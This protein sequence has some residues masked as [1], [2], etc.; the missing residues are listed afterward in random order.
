MPISDKY[1][2]PVHAMQWTGYNNASHVLFDAS[3]GITPSKTPCDKIDSEQPWSQTHISL[4][5][6]NG[7]ATYGVRVDTARYSNSA[8]STWISA[9]LAASTSDNNFDASVRV[10]NAGG[11]GDADVAAL[12]FLC[13]DRYA[14]K[15]Y[16]RADGYFGIGGGNRTSWAWYLSPS[17]DMVVSGNVTAYSDPRLKENF[18][19]VSDPLGILKALDGGTFTWK[20]GFPHTASKAGNRDYGVLADQVQAVMPEVVTK[21]IEIDGEAYLTVSYEKLVPVL[22]EAVKVLVA[23]VEELEKR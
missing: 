19:K 9:P 12:L 23:R 3:S 16:Q 22:I 18:Q 17:N 5:G 11:E 13:T 4:M 15:M 8:N 7:S 6:W 1:L 20:H 21:S 2:F 14:T 10:R